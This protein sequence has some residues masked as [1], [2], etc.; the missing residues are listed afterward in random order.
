MVNNILRSEHPNAVCAICRKNSRTL[1]Q[2]TAIRQWAQFVQF[3]VCE[4]HADQARRWDRV[5]AAFRERQRAA[6]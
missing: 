1:I 6:A 4:G 5:E 2:A 3:Y